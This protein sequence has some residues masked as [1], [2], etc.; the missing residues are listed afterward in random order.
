MCPARQTSYSN[1]VDDF[2]RCGL[3]PTSLEYKYPSLVPSNYDLCYV[4]L[5]SAK[6]SDTPLYCMPSVTY[7]S[8]PEDNGKKK[9]KVC[10]GLCCSCLTKN[11]AA[12]LN[13][14]K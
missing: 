12:A 6:V 11:L 2:P 3:S 9:K 10:D 1:L 14:L 8:L 4:N 7:F 13:E 5:G